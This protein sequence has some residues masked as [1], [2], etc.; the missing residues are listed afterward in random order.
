VGSGL[1]ASVLPSLRWLQGLVGQPSG[2][3]DCAASG[4][5]HGQKGPEPEGCMSSRPELL[6][7]CYRGVADALCGLGVLGGLRLSSPAGPCRGGGGGRPPWP[8]VWP[9]GVGVGALQV[10]AADCG[11]VRRLRLL[12]EAAVSVGRVRDV[13]A[14]LTGVPVLSWPGSWE[15]LLG[16][17]HC[18][19]VAGRPGLS[20]PVGVGVRGGVLQ[21]RGLGAGRGGWVW[22]V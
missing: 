5:V 7:R 21:G 14:G 8:V 16:L 11:D 18:W 22:N 2:A 6:E 15:C 3:P 17:L 13:A 20:G 12:S 1:P 19:L 10:A 9:G 4:V